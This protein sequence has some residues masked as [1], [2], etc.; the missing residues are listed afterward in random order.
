[1]E[2]LRPQFMTVSSFVVTKES[3]PWRRYSSM[4]AV[5]ASW[6]GS[7]ERLASVADPADG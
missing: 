1:M 5:R 4:R 2:Y 7:W 3:L 6:P